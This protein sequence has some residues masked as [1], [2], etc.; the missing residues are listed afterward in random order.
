ML[1]W[2]AAAQAQI[3]G[4]TVNAAIFW[5]MSTTPDPIRL[6]S[7]DGDYAHE[8]DALETE[9]GAIYA[10][11]GLLASALPTLTSLLNGQADRVEFQ[12]SGAGV[13]AEV[14]SLASAS[15][16]DIRNVDV[17][18]GFAA[19]GWDQQLLSPTAWLWTGV[20]DTLRVIRQADENGV[21]RTLSLS[22][23]SL[24]TGRRRATPLYFTPQDQRARSS[25]DAFCDRVP[26]YNE[27]TT[28]NW[29]PS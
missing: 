17:N 9:A 15:A 12:I 10:G 27:G 29:P 4:G 1:D 13:S 20:A 23:G 8:A 24:L 3:A 21:T 26:G 25:D 2:S 28:I 5:R 22:C 7:G 6:W 18:V 11:Y 16:A 14:A 19:L